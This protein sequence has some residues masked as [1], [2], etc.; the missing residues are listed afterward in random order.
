MVA[1][2]PSDFI[3]SFLGK[4]EEITRNILAATVGKVLIIDEAY[5]LYSGRGEG[6]NDSYK[7]AVIDTLVAE[8]Q[9]VPGDDQ[10]IILLGY[11]DKLKEMFQNVNP[12]LHRRFGVDH[13]FTF[14]NFN[15]PQLKQI[16]EQKMEQQDLRATPEAL[17]V[18]CD[19][20][21]RV[22]IRPNYSNAG[23]VVTLLDRAK[24]NHQTRQLKRPPVERVCDVHFEPVDFDPKYARHVASV[25]NVQSQLQNL[26]GGDIIQKLEDY[27]KLGHMAKFSG[28]HPCDLVPTNI[29]FKGPSGE[30]HHLLSSSFGC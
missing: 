27:L 11:E 24:I 20:L 14:E 29:L 1:K 5:M 28:F 23:E 26:V 18:A 25:A 6:Q 13:A 19:V 10:C 7:T 4:S 2:N 15:V 30:Y 22:R 16:L 3:G 21:D 17:S 8:V 9:G 12:G